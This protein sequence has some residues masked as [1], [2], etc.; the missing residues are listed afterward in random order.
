MSFF[1]YP[2]GRARVFQLVLNIDRLG[3]S[4]CTHLNEQRHQSVA[5]IYEFIEMLYNMFFIYKPE[6][7]IVN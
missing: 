3:L 1:K 2:R 5:E 4:E 6:L 7:R